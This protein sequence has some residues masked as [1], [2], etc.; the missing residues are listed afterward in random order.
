MIREMLFFSKLAKKNNIN[1]LIYMHGRLSRQSQ[2]IKK[3]FLIT[4]WSG[5]IFF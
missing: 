2:I 1:T 5:V 4:I 3:T